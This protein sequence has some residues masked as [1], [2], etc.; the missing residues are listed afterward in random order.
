[1][2]SSPTELLI[3]L[4]RA[5]GTSLA[6]Q[7]EGQIRAAVRAGTLQGG[8][9][10][11]S[12]RDFAQQF[13]ISRPLVVEAYAQLAAEG[14]LVIRQGA[15]PRVADYTAPDEDARADSRAPATPPRF[16]FLPAVPDLSSFP[17]KTWLKAYREALASMTGEDFGYGERHGSLALR[18][19]LLDYLGRVRGVATGADRILITNG[20]EQGRGLVC[21]ALRACGVRRIAVED[22]SYSEW[23]TITQAGLDIVPVPVDAEG[24]SVA[25]L[26]KT[27]AEAVMVTPAHQFPTGVV[28]SGE[29]RLQLVSWLRRRDAF[30]L[31]DDYDAEFRYDRAPVG[32]L[33]GMAPAHVVY[34]GTA[35]KTLAPGLRLGWVVVPPR[36]LEA[37]RTEQVLADYGCPRIEQHALARFI[38][39]GELDRHLR[40]M[41]VRYKAQRDA[42]LSALAIEFPD[43]K[44]RGVAAGLHAAV[45]LKQDDDEQA[46]VEEARR[47]HVAVAFLSAHCIARRDIPPTLLL[48]YA[49]QAES[50]IRAGVHA[51]A[52]A[53]GAARR[54]Q[55]GEIQQDRK[56][57]HPDGA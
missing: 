53:I 9:V 25:D 48:G 45:E 5:S 14:Y 18:R 1:L 23:E 19:A 11:A 15:R 17:R 30:A 41:R 50:A 54:G 4:T 44:P 26:E 37:V 16:N 20:F 21:R 13:G 27:Q 3:H 52:A 33:Q 32:S 24:I 36:L 31:E 40:R 46:I 2:T 38:G 8:T 51:L 39:A 47:R 6:V 42:L 29:R 10:L 28:M 35:S 7:I 22:P 49:R 12:T 57:T 34:A 43:L 56:K 55:T